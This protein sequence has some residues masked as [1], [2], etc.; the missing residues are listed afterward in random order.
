MEGLPLGEEV[1]ATDSPTTSKG[2]AGCRGHV[3][4]GLVPGAFSLPIPQSLQ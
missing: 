3:V 1:Q 2:Q 4:Y